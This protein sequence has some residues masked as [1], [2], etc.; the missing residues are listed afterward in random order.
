MSLPLPVPGKPLRD[1]ERS[2]GD[3]ARHPRP[4]GVE[5]DVGGHG[6]A[7][8]GPSEGPWLQFEVAGV[9]PVEHAVGPTLSFTLDVTD[10]S[11]RNVFTAALT[12]QIQ[13]EPVKRRYEDSERERLAEL[14]G[15]PHRWATSAQRMPWTTESVL[16]RNFRGTTSVDVEVLCNYDLELAATR[17]FHSVESGEIPL[18]FHFNGS[19]YYAGEG[20]TLQVVQVPWDTVADAKMPVAVW[21]RMIDSYYPYRGWLPLQRETLDELLARKAAKGLPTY[22]HVVRELLDSDQSQ[23]ASRQGKAPEQG[24]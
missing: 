2:N 13:I 15:E 22:D 7:E 21:K 14:F 8:T 19:V 16:L 17:Y 18:S 4:P 24:S 5:S 11:D 20:G 12:I 9:R 23:V 1:E 10:R 6:P 3:G